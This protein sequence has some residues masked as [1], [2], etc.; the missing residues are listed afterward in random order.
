M[1]TTSSGEN[2]RKRNAIVRA[3]NE[4]RNFNLAATMTDDDFTSL[5]SDYFHNNVNSDRELSSSDD[6]ASDEEVPDLPSIVS[7]QNESNNP[8]FVHDIVD[9]QVED[10]DDGGGVAVSSIHVVFQLI[11][12]LN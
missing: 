1:A 11:S 8:N 3:V 5:I 7:D 6:D 12:Q 10:S 4:I 9:D 2:G